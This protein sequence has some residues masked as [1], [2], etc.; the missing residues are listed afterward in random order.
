MKSVLR[1][2]AAVARASVGAARPQFV[3]SSGF[4]SAALVGAALLGSQPALANDELRPTVVTATRNTQLVTAAVPHTTVITREDIERSQATD[5][6]SLLQREAG[7]QRTQNGGIGTVSSVFVRGAPSLQTLVLVDGIPQ[8]KQDASGAISLEHIMLENVDRIEVVRGNV[9]AVYGSGA[10]GGVI[11]IFTR[12]A[13]PKPTGSV[14]METGPRSTS[15]GGAQVSARIGTTSLS[16]GASRLTTQGFSALDPTQRPTANPD[17]DGYQNSS[18]NLSMTHAWAKGQEIGVRL[19]QSEGKTEFDS[20]FGAPA[21]LQLSVTRLNQSSVFLDQQLGSWR[22]R[23]SV[24]EQ[25]DKSQTFDNGTFGSTDGFKTSASLLNWTNN[26]QLESGWLLTG[27]VDLQRQ[28]VSTY[29]DVSTPYAGN[30]NATAVFA[31][32]EGV[33]GPGNLQVNLRA[34]RVGRLSKSTGFVGYSLP[35]GQGWEVKGSTATAFNAPPLG[36]LFAPFFGNPALQP[37]TASS[38]ELGLQ[39]D[40]DTHS[41]RLTWFDTKVSNQLD[42][43]FSTAKFQNIGKT[44]NQGVELTYRGRIGERSDL[45]GS[46]TLQ[47]PRNDLSNERLSRR[48]RTLMSAGLTQQVG[49]WEIDADLRYQGTRRDTSA[50]AGSQRLEAYTVLDMAMTYPLSKSLQFKAR[51]ENVGDTSYQTVYGYN[52]TPRSVYVGLTWRPE[53]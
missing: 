17:A 7:L 52:Q 30:R 50:P 26:Y 24:S 25:S 5:L 4:R 27:G 15:R 47:D 13:G 33:A 22:S 32:V 1:N 49:R 8:N 37:E 2:M 14:F 53:F 35:L 45:R 18:A 48:A 44:S 3:L 9:S 43:D 11:Q 10:I 34:D 31:G 20:A 28:R 39:Y 36:Y 23:F 42:Y 6:L 19:S 38:R 16:A 40:N 29:S 21:D 46:V 51:V 41:L 12:S